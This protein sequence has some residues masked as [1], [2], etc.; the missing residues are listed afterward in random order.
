MDVLETFE[1]AV[2]ER[3]R[4]RW[5]Q[6]EDRYQSLK[7]ACMD[8]QPVPDTAL[9]VA[10]DALAGAEREWLAAVRGMPED[11]VRRV[12]RYSE[13]RQLQG[14]LAQVMEQVGTGRGR[15]VRRMEIRARLRE[16]GYPY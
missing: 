7:R 6:A 9:A 12:A 16:L 14:E 10:R 3:A 8:L 11:V 13:V 1:L 5:D 15:L 4:L 2:A